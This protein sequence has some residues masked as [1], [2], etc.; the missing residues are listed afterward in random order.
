[1]NSTLSI[2]M[3]VVLSV[4][5]LVGTVI[6]TVWGHSLWLSKQFSALRELIYSQVK[7][8]ENNFGNKLDYHERQDDRRFSEVHNEIWEMKIKAAANQL[9]TNIEKNKQKV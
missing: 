3:S 6:T 8:L 1:M 5:V 2:D 9:E 4:L 7:N